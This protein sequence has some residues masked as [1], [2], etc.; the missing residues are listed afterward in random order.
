MKHRFLFLGIAFGLALS[1]LS[2]VNGRSAARAETTLLVYTAVE[3]EWLPRYKKAF[4]DAN[5]GIHIKWLREGT[6]TLT[7]RLLAEKDAPR[8]DAVFGLAASSLL[9][10]K[11]QNMLDPYT[12]RDFFKISPVMRDASDSPCWVGINAW[13]TAFCVNRL[14][15][16]KRGLAA[17][18]NWEDLTRPEYKDLI[19]M[20]DPAASGT[21]YMNLAAWIQMW[22]EE[23][24]WA[25]VDAVR[26]NLKMLSPSGARPA[27]MAAQGEI[28]IGVSSGAFGAPFVKRRAPLDIIVP[29]N[30]GW[31]MEASAIVKGTANLEAARRLMDFCC[32]EAVAKIGA[33]FSG[34]PARPEFVADRAAADRLA[35]VD[36]QWGADNRE[37]L[38]AAWRARYGN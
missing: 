37:R 15:M 3:P 8:A 26:A 24:A 19:V 5:P 33:E 16:E 34:M 23:K 27:A 17:P 11:A 2:P 28:P 25:Y 21:G 13:A 30:A 10:L 29:D 22:G 1:V 35:P 18:R 38:L 20:P 4:E 6:G 36:P 31:E 14:E 9:V 12:P 7:A 32:S